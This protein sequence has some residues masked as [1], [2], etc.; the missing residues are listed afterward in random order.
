[1]RTR[2]HRIR[3]LTLPFVLAACAPG[4]A[5]P[6]G[7]T[8][9]ELLVSVRGGEVIAA[10]S[11][12]SGWHRVRVEEERGG[13]ILVVFRLLDTSASDTSAFLQELDSASVTPPSAVALGGPEVGT[14]GEVVIRFTPG[15]YL[16]GCVRRGRDGHRHA[17]RGEAKIIVV[18]DV[19]GASETAE[20]VATERVGMVDFAY[21]GPDR[22]AA[23][24]HMLRVANAGQQDHQL[25]IAR[26]HEGSSLRDW[27]DAEEPAD[28]AT[29]IAG[30]ARLGA[31]ALA[32]LPVDLPP[33]IY[34][35]FCLVSDA[36]SG[37]P[38]VALGMFREIRVEAREPRSAPAAS[39][40]PPDR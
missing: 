4:D 7:A 40:A 9:R 11:I 3:L 32:Y 28:H 25:R 24:T 23:G 10:D 34:V 31:G 36:Q 13:H 30:V 20:P 8:E 12:E 26:M 22:W 16:L 18:S 29:P 15:R 27:M 37:K 1:M 14:T 21:I 2:R 6:G 19:P 38:H 5:G 39:A 35:L 17:A 33:G